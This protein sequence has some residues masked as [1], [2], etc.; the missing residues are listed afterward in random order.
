MNSKRNH[1]FKIK[2]ALE[3]LI[4]LSYSAFFLK[5]IINGSVSMYVHPRIIPFMIF[6]SA[7]MIVI[8]FLMMKSVIRQDAEKGRLWPLIFYVIPII[9]AFIIPPQSFDSNTA[10]IGEVQLKSG[11]YA[12]SDFTTNKRTSQ[13]NS[14]S[15]ITGQA[16]SGSELNIKPEENLSNTSSTLYMD[17]DNFVECMNDVYEDVDSYVGMPI[18][19][20]GFVYRDEQ[21]FK[22]NEFV[23]ARLM[24]VCCAADMQPVGF[25]CR[26][27]KSDSIKTGA[28]VKVDGTIDKTEYGGDTIPFIKVDSIQTTEKPD[29][30]YVYP[31]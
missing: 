10:T 26:F 20:I 19:A 28:W 22:T 13:N 16:D 1:F 23:A 9:M 30:E 7:A 8:A 4:L 11:T 5:S 15:Q 25:L 21:Q 14:K 31:Y 18:E 12:G 27:G 24:M 3:I 6:T 29:T 17:T 2:R